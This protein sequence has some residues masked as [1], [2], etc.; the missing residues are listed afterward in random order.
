MI[1]NEAV[2]IFPHQLFRRS[3]ILDLDCTIYLIE[4]FLFFK[5]YKFHKQKLVFHRASMKAYETYLTSIGKKVISRRR[6][7]Y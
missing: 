2:L 6:S 5:H 1:T 7:Y 4:D 3:E